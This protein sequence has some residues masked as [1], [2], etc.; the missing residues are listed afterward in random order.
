MQFDQL[1]QR[2]LIALLGGAAAWPRAN[3][4]HRRADVPR[5][6]PSACAGSCCCARAGAAAIELDEQSG[7]ACARRFKEY[8]LGRKVAE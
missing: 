4:A 6:R 2:E 5:S 1:K 7:V 3:A 8:G